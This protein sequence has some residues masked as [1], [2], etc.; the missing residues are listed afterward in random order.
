MTDRAELLAAI[1]AAPEDDLPR[2]VFADW[3]EECGEELIARFICRMIVA[4]LEGKPQFDESTEV[5]AD[6]AALAALWFNSFASAFG[7]EKFRVNRRFISRVELPVGTFVARA[8][9][10]FRSQPIVEVDLTDAAR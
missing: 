2:L 8:A 9:D 7:V 4:D 5:V 6:Q 1:T 10:L 3:M